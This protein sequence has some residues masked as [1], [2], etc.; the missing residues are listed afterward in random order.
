MRPLLNCWI[1]AIWLWAASRGRAL[2]WMRRSLHFRGVIPHA[3]TC[4]HAGR[5]RMRMVEYIPCK[6]AL[7]SRRN[8][9]FLFDGTY[10]VWEFR[11]VRVRRF[12]S[13]RA[14]RAYLRGKA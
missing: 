1:V 6:A 14:V 11:A 12:S 5:R 2:I 9:V 3:G 7:W 8:F 4:H 10:R 13:M